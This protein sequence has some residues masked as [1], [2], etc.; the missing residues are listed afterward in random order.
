MRAQIL[1][2]V[3]TI[4]NSAKDT[5]NSAFTKDKRSVTMSDEN[6]SSNSDDEETGGSPKPKKHRVSIEEQEEY[7]EYDQPEARDDESDDSLE[8]EVGFEEV[9]GEDE[10]VQQEQQEP[11]EPQDPQGHGEDA[12]T[13]ADADPRLL[14]G[15]EDMPGAPLLRPCDIILPCFRCLRPLLSLCRGCPATA[16]RR[17]FASDDGPGHQTESG[18]LSNRPT[19][20]LGGL[21]Q[22]Q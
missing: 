2:L 19:R 5:N 13:E 20:V 6:S 18:V 8:F 4:A 1:R 9:E 16:L 10:V 14:V 7:H 22:D 11:Q 12:E 15:L 3:C 17:I 21:E